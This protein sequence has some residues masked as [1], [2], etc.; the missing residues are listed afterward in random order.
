MLLD[1]SENGGANLDPPAPWALP[2]EDD[3]AAYETDSRASSEDRKYERGKRKYR[4]ELAEYFFK[5]RRHGDDSHESEWDGATLDRKVKSRIKKL[6][7]KT[8]YKGPGDYSGV[9]RR[10]RGGTKIWAFQVD[11]GP[12]DREPWARARSKWLEKKL[13]AIKMRH[14][15]TLGWGGLGVV[16]LFEQQRP[17]GELLKVVC[18]V[19]IDGNKKNLVDEIQAHIATAGAMHV[20]QRI[21]P[22]YLGRPN[23]KPI[24]TEGGI[25]TNLLMMTVSDDEEMARTG[26]MPDTH[27]WDSD[28]VLFLEF[29]SRGDL[30]KTATKISTSVTD[31]GNFPPLALWHIFRNRKCH[32]P[33]CLVITI[34]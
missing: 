12:R 25:E 1:D 27:V 21:P 32:T 20:S 14:I 26:G 22:G 11:S 7:I 6:P 5:W 8:S 31:G 30:R 33:L 19:D 17:D 2:T 9:A 4:N 28:Q 16:N 24:Q 10:Y 18:K 13:R 3:N 34:N 29:M 15:K 23:G